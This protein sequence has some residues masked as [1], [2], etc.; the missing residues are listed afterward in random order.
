MSSEKKIALLKF[1]ASPTSSE[2]VVSALFNG[3]VP[4]YECELWDYKLTIEDSEAA[5]AELCRDVVSFYNS[6]GGYLIFGVS[7]SGDIVGVET[8][9][10]TDKQ[11]KQKLRSFSDHDVVVRLDYVIFK[12]VSL[13][14]LAIPKRSEDTGVAVMVKDGPK[15]YDKPVFRASSV[16]FRSDESSQLIRDSEDMRFLASGR[17]HSL[18][19]VLSATSGF[20]PNNLPDRNMICERFIGRSDV[21]EKLWLW[22]SDPMSR[23]RV[24]A[25]PGGFGKS[26]AAYSFCED[27]IS[28][29]PLGFLQ[30][31][32][33][34]AKTKQFNPSNNT[35]VQLAYS[36]SSS[37]SFFDIPSLLDAIAEHLPVS[38][39]EVDGLSEMAVA[40]SLQVCLRQIPS[41][42]VIDDLDSLDPDDQ[43]RVIELAMFLGGERARF[44]I[45]TRK[46]YIAPATSTTSLPGL[47]GNDFSQY[48]EILEKRYGRVLGG[49]NLNVLMAETAGSPLFAES[50]FRLMK[51]GEKFKDAIDRW[52]GSDGEAARAAAFRKELDNLKFNSK[53]ALFA[54][55]NFESL[56]SIEIRKVAELE[57]PQVEEALTELDQLF[58]LSSEEIAGEARFSVPRNI[59]RLLNEHRDE[60]IPNHKEILQRAKDHRQI[61]GVKGKARGV[62]LFV[63][64]VIAQ[65]MTQLA[66]D[67]QSALKTIEAATEI[68]SQNPDLWMVYARC[69]SAQSSLDSEGV[70]KAFAKSYQYGKRERALFEKWIEFENGFGNSNAA[71]DVAERGAKILVPPPWDWLV[72][73]AS[74]YY[75]RGS[76]RLSRFEK[77]DAQSDFK[78]SANLLSKALKY[79]PDA[80]K[81]SVRAALV[82]ANVPLENLTPKKGINLTKEKR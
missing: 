47:E 76:E 73:V 20:V 59:S 75:K 60:L 52:K 43:R 77:A 23:Y 38:S 25:G 51:F 36:G 10:Y 18:E 72:L 27:V 37:D 71:I 55:S 58:L 17:H 8:F 9:P 79:A 12:G 1:L 32:W 69:L 45:T 44:L 15:K 39:E 30:V 2:D 54:I 67:P 42:F 61:S 26:S 34:S 66:S 5:L 48:V 31:V 4:K 57:Q 13:A 65:A 28:A 21:K 46:N 53:R 19:A 6:Y 64:K 40:Q 70:R 56:S 68:E 62:S 16:Y 24:I 35:F 29:A 63:G 82:R 22:L 80:A 14:C 81:S 78:L 49:Q 3:G 50:V 7:D 33:L 11:I 41:F 74:A